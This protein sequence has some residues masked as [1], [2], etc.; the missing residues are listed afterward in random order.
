MC[1][2]IMI[3]VASG[4]SKEQISDKETIKN[5]QTAIEMVLSVQTNKVLPAVTKLEDTYITHLFIVLIVIFF[6]EYVS[7]SSQKF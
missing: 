3:R 5:E 7:V 4:D 6:S 1:T 2:S